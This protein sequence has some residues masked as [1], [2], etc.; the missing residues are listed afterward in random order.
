MTYDGNAVLYPQYTEVV[1]EPSD[2]EAEAVAR[3]FSTW[4]RPPDQPGIPP[5]PPQPE[6]FLFTELELP[7]TTAEDLAWY[8]SAE[9]PVLPL[10]LLP[11]VHYEDVFPVPVFSVRVGGRR[12]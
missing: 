4:Y 1:G 10:P 2:L 8:R 12:M 3:F 7:D 11:G 6:A 5:P 9:Q